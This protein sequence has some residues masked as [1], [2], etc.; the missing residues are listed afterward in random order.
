[1]ANRS[2]LYSVDTIPTADRQPS[3]IR[4]VSEFNWDIALYHRVLMTGGP[5][6][7][8]SAIWPDHEIGI[9]ADY[10]AGTDRLLRLLELVRGVSEELDRSID[11]SREVL[12]S[13]K[14]RGRYLLLEAG[15]I[16]DLL[17]EDLV[18]Q[19]DRLVNIELPGTASQVD[20][21]LA[22]EA[23]DW[24]SQLASDWREQ[25]DL[26]WADVLYFDFGV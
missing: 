10:A 17:D 18:D 4:S 19:A 3:P 25:L 16:F 9:V 21:A 1:M 2:Y 5:R 13:D 23:D 8:Q 6:R 7:C 20:R 14:H 15:E 26:Y 22:G 24:V 12:A 11:A